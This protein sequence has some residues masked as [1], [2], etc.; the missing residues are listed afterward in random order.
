[1]PS[2]R[3]DRDPYHGGTQSIGAWGDFMIY[4]AQAADGP[5]KIGYTS[6][7]AKARVKV[8]SYGSKVPVRLLATMVGTMKDE[9]SF[10]RLF[11]FA[12]VT[13]EWFEPTRLLMELI[14]GLAPNGHQDDGLPAI[15]VR[16]RIDEELQA[17]LDKAQRAD[18]FTTSALLVRR[19]LDAYL[20]PLTDE[21]RAALT[22]RLAAD[23]D[24]VIP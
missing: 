21:E 18:R 2:Q 23:V 22:P 1:M 16:A 7:N 10:H 20:P 3:D 12:R 14:A 15:E 19:A 13:G 17:R 5:V 8:I 11:W 24:E 4:F 6:H 9:R